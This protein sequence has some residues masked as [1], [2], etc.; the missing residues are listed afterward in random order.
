MQKDRFFDT[1][2]LGIHGAVNLE[3]LKFKANG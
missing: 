2:T 3:Y 1:G